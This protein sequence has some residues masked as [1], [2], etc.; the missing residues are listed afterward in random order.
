[1]KQILITIII[2]ASF[3]LDSGCTNKN[4]GGMVVMETSL[5]TL[6]IKLYDETPLHKANFLKLVGDGYYNGLIFHRVIPNFMAQAGDPNSKNAAPN[7]QL[8]SGGPGYTIHAEIKPNLFHQKGALSAA[9][10]G[11]NVNPKKKAAEASST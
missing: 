10:Q 3:I 2:V 8:G 7:V 6:K 4:T 1:M 9:R 11:D 5:G